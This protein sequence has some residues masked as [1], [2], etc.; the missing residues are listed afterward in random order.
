[1]PWAAGDPRVSV[2]IYSLNGQE[3]VTLQSGALGPGEYQVQW[4]GADAFGRPVA[5]GTYFCKLQ[6]DD[7]SVTRRLVYLR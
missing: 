4:D 5:S 3:L 6:L 2:K 7:W 1:M